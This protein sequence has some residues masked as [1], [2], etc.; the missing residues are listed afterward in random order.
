MQVCARL[1]PCADDEPSA[2]STS[3]VEETAKAGIA[4]WQMERWPGAMAVLSKLRKHDT[5]AYCGLVGNPRFTAKILIFCFSDSE[6][7][8]FLHR[9]APSLKKQVPSQGSVGPKLKPRPNGSQRL[10]LP[11]LGRDFTS[12]RIPK[13]IPKR[14]AF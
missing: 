13:P 2:I 12:Q 9:A 6:P 11:K 5:F 4:S 1:R 10:G 7:Y 14:K 3:Q 8:F